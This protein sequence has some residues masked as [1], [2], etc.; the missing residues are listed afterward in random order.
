MVKVKGSDSKHNLLV[1]ITG[2]TAVGKTSVAIQIARALGTEIISCD[3]RQFY[4]EMKIG[5]AVPT[6]EELSAVKHHFI[7]FLPITENYDVIR[8]ESDA[9]MLLNV[10]FS[11][12]QVVVMTG[13]SGLYIDA[14][15][16]GF[17]DLP[18]C[19]PNLRKELQHLYKDYGLT[20]LQEKLRQL[21][22]EY[23]EL[24]DKNNPNRLLR[25]VE[26]CLISGKTYTQLRQGNKK[27]RPFRILKIALN[28]NRSE[29]FE[30]ISLRTDRMIAT[31]LIEEAKSLLPYR[32]LN[33]LNTVGYKELFRYFDGSCILEQAIEDIKTNTRRYAKRQLTWLKKDMAY[34]WFEPTEFEQIHSMI[35]SRL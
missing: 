23:F 28:L 17:D 10:L 20:A 4:S 25:A 6:T 12:H 26:V 5:T 11:Q 8:F 19:D 24:V 7:G 21:D 33:A 2:P 34:N 29:L 13:G 14:V 32:H 16:Q 3:S 22:P 18:D 9:L 31:G 27:E 1:V 15:C 35:G 30:R